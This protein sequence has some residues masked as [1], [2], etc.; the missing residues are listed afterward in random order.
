M[1]KV[2]V[3]VAENGMIINPGNFE[4]ILLKKHEIINK[5][6]MIEIDIHNTF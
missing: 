3:M 4:V 1:V 6:D 5:V 2:V